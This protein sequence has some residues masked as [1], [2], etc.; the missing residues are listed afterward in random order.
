MLI[1]TPT[2]KLES[3]V[4]LSCC[5][6]PVEGNCS[7]WKKPTH[8]NFT[9]KGSSHPASRFRPR[10]F[11]LCTTVLLTE[12]AQLF[13]H[14][15]TTVQSWYSE[16]VNS[17]PHFRHQ[18]FYVSPTI[19]H[20]QNT[21]MQTNTLNVTQILEQCLDNE[22]FCNITKNTWVFWLF[23]Y[24]NYTTTAQQVESW[25]NPMGPQLSQSS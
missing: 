24:S 6:W 22:F 9:Q 3:P 10:P 2:D 7:T 25:H 23:V 18:P 16:T 20:I 8:A 11:L 13:L 14:N 17:N 1:V 5:L 12:Q 19:H 15:E 4:S 21:D